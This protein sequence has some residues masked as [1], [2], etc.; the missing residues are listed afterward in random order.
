MLGWFLPTI[1]A[2]LIIHLIVARFFCCVGLL[3][4]NT[5]MFLRHVRLRALVRNAACFQW[6]A[7]MRRMRLKEAR[8]KMKYAINAST[9]KLNANSDQ[10]L[11]L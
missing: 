2:V 11:L 6:G 7:G 4:K 10:E 5:T 8:Y 1:W 9:K 3:N